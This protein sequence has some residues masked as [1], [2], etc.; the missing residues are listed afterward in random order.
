[1]GI[2]SRFGRK[3]S[4]PE[5]SPGGSVVYRYAND[6]WQQTQVGFTERAGE[7]GDLRDAVYRQRFGEAKQVWHEV[8]PLVPHID[9]MEYYRS[10]ESGEVC[11]LVTSG[12]S[13]LPMRVPEN[14]EVPRRVEIIFYSTEPKR[15]YIETMRQLAHFPH[16]QKTWI[17]SFHTIP[18][19]NPPEPLWGT[20]MDTF[21]FLPP[22]VRKDRTLQDDLILDGDH[23]EFLW[24]AP[25]TSAECKLKLAKGSGAILDLFQKNKHSH[26][27]NPERSGYV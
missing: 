26:I 22:I 23:V 21:F 16:D 9:V 17:G 4:E 7:Y 6:Q 11:V 2:F 3:S 5:I 27:F 14:A 1:M 10:G 15:E 20:A 13:N 24:L 19:G 8:I 25:L 18:N 12:M